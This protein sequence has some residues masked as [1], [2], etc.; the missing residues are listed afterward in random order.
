MDRKP[1][2]TAALSASLLDAS[3]RLSTR[4]VFFHQA[5]AHHLGLHVTDHKC[6]DLVL[7]EGRVTAGR[8]AEWTG[9]T[10]GAITSVINRLEKAGFVRRVKDPHDLRIVYVEPVFDRL[11]PVLDVFAPL[12]EAM[13]ALHARYSAGE[14]RL[15]LDY[16]ERAAEVLV[17]QA[18]RLR[19]SPR[20]GGRRT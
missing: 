13:S 6:L 3:K 16:V 15:I 5:V 11:Q 19:R 18:E 9:L 12:G 4:T 7:E 2:E 8:L 1:P 17:N 10:T 14:L 20:R